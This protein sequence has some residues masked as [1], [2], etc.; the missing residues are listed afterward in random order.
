M[1]KLITLTACLLALTCTLFTSCHDD[2][3]YMIKQE[4]ALEEKGISG[5]I[6]S[7]VRFTCDSKEYIYLTN[8]KL[9]RRDITQASTTSGLY[10]EQWERIIN[11]SDSSSDFAGEQI[12]YLASDST[13]LYAM[14]TSYEEDDNGYNVQSYRKI[15]CTKKGFPSSKADWTDITETLGI[16]KSN[17]G[18][19]A[20]V[21]QIKTLFSNRAYEQTNR[22]AYVRLYNIAGDSATHIYQLNGE[23]APSLIADGTNNASSSSIQA[24]YFNGSDYFTGTKATA[25]NDKYIYYTSGSALYY[26]DS[27]DASSNAFL[28]GSESAKSV[29]LDKGQILDIAV[30]KDFLLLGTVNGIAHVTL[31]ANSI[32]ASATTA[33]TNNAVSTLTSAY[34]VYTVFSRDPYVNEYDND[35]WGTTTIYGS[36]SSSSTSG[37]FNELGLWAYYPDRTASGSTYG[38]WNKDG[39][40]DGESKGN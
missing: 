7:I 17:V 8:G 38:T 34:R 11:P 24:V 31:D 26:A 9:Y 35:L 30:S 33:F 6:E 5:D 21:D 25:A 12:I 18:T 32:P 1:K 27:Y 14:T 3:Y 39:T 40:A 37:L 29:A 10:N 16:S 15:Y 36:L 20:S 4:V 13:Y 23:N 2:I 19:T 28:T 22:K